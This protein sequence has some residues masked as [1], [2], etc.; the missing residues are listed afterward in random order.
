LPDIDA[1]LGRLE[2]GRYFR[3]WSFA[4][5]R[6]LGDESW[7]AEMD[8]LFARAARAYV[9]GTFSLAG[10]AYERLLRAF[11]LEGEGE[12]FCG[13]RPAQEMI[14]TDLDEAKARYLRVRYGLIPL[15]QRAPRLLQELE[16]LAHVGGWRLGLRQ[17]D[18][19]GLDPLPEL[20]AFLPLWLEQL[21]AAPREGRASAYPIEDM[22]R[23]L[24]REAVA[25]WGGA[26]GLKALAREEGAWHPEAYGAWI[27]H[28]RSTGD[29]AAAISAAR[30]GLLRVEEPAERAALAERLA[31]FARE[32]ESPELL[33]EALRGAFRAAPSV[34][35]LARLF[36]AIPAEE[37]AAAASAELDEARRHSEGFPESLLAWLEMLRGEA[38]NALRLLSNASPLGWSRSEHPGPVVAPALLWAASRAPSLPEGSA[39]ARLWRDADREPE[40]PPQAEPDA[41]RALLREALLR[42]PLSAT[43]AQE[44]LDLCARAAERRARAIISNKHRRAYARAARLLV[45]CTEAH[46]LAGSPQDG[47]HF[48]KTVRDELRR[49]HSFREELDRAVNASPWLG[50]LAP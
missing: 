47:D 43:Q 25:L 33:R 39:L 34:G 15:E 32:E 45:A 41:P 14:S 30:E 38:R 29:R 31:V 49:H 19:A 6:A 10:T 24:L 28:L 21:R 46:Y 13:P 40:T 18:E 16:S 37:R 5:G 1:F 26:A 23:A 22:R 11:L 35:R 36:F 4:E 48:L 17:L 44:A 3:E 9:E 50:T 2:A 20:S 42:V 27:D 12:I 7:A 8:A